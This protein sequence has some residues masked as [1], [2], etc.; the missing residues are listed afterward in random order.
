MAALLIITVFIS[1]SP[2]FAQRQSVEL[3]VLGTYSAGVYNQ[4]AS[5][6]VA[7]DP[8]TQRL[9]TVNGATSKID[10]LSIIDPS[11]PILLFSIDIAPYGRQANSVAVKRGIVAAAVEANVKT[12]HGKAVFFDTDGNYLN[13]VTVGAL[14]DMV[15]FTPD[16]KKVLVANE[17]EPSN[18]YTIDP[19]GSV[20]IIDIDFGVQNADVTTANF[21]AFNSARLNSSIRIFGP[22]ATVAQ[23]LEPE[24]IAVSD[25]S[26]TAWIT[27]QENNAVGVLDLRT[28]EFTRL[29]GLGFKDH[30]LRRNGIDSSDRISS[31]TPGVIEILPRPVFGMYQ[32]DGIATFNH[33][34]ETFFITAN[35]GDARDYAGFTE[36]VRIN[37]LLLDPAVFPDATFLKTD[38]Q[39]GRLNVTKTLGNFDGDA[40]YEALFAFGARS[41]S[42]WT[43]HG[44]QVY[45]SGDD[46]EQITAQTYPSFFN[47]GNTNN[48]RDDRSDNKGPEPEGVTTGFAYGRNYAFIGLERI[49]GVLVYEISD[50][51]SPIFVQ[52][53]NN[54][55]FT[56]AANTAAAGDLGPEGLH[57]ISLADSPTDT[58][59]LVVANEVSGTTTIYEIARNR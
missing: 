38:A 17:G 36:E 18:D 41:F 24:Y 47:A 51:R 59:L 43:G 8:F 50:P 14:P 46:I 39:I 21:R 44:E 2:I 19:E 32:P 29:I 52:Y 5:E 40:K 53:I 45:D 26:R 57:F 34:G 23:D 7:H 30:S 11:Q 54:R 9:Y 10:V 56:A 25:D 37:S 48:T 3:R 35:E 55:N 49:G 1:I 12:D 15:T 16:G 33:L 22:N 58:P 42:I 4:G 27:L 20:S 13:A 28:G 31:S 6:I